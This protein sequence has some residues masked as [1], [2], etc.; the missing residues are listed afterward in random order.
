MTDFLTNVRIEK[1][2][3]DTRTWDEV[4]FI[5]FADNLEGLR[6]MFRAANRRGGGYHRVNS[7]EGVVYGTTNDDPIE[8]ESYANEAFDL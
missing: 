5:G 4:R 7:N 6:N 3:E 8:A 1:F 2:N